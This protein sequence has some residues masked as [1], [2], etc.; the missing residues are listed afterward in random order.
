M[1]AMNYLIQHPEIKHGKVRVAFTPDEEIGRGPHKFDVAQFG[2]QFAYTVD[3]GPLGELEY[4]SFNAAEAKITIK[5]KNVHPGT[6]KGKMINSIKI[7]WEFQQQLPANEAPEHTDGYEG[8][9]HLLSSKAMWR[10]QSCITLSAIL[11]AS[12]LRHARQ[13]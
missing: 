11:T 8:F 6:A 10:K 5:G 12:N 2:A 1:T 4:E 3:G 13:K 7:A 9:Y